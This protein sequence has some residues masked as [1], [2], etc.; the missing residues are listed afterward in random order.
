[1]EWLDKTTIAK[2]FKVSEATI[3]RLRKIGMPCIKVGGS[4]RFDL[5][6][7]LEWFKNNEEGE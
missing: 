1:M 7:V 2:E 3:D 5:E 4:V 6:T